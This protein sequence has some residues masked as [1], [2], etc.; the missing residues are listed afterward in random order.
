MIF[1]P[2]CKI[3]LGL[4][5][6]DKRVDGYHNIETVFLPISL[7][8]IIEFIP[9]KKADSNHV[10][11]SF[12]GIHIDGS[13][14]NNLCVK[15]YNLLKKISPNLP[16]IQ[17][18]IHKIIPIGAGLGGGSADGAFMLKELNHFFALKF[19]NTQLQSLALELGSDCP[20][21]IENK[22]VFAQG[23]GEEFTKIELDLSNYTIIILYPNISISTKWAFENVH[24]KKTSTPLLEKIKYPINQWK[25]CIYNDFEESVF[26]KFP[27]LQKIK[28]ELYDNNAIYASLSGTGSVVYGIFKNNEQKFNLQNA[29]EKNIKQFNATFL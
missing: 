4:E 25:D 11:C 20:F 5:L 26:K 23:R 19:S 1:Y 12:T 29:S 16:P 2:N 13:I 14:E 10:I 22:P 6:K 21:F 9:L 8:D 7:Y 17:M 3:N 28:N 24:I 27:I 18:H 15:A